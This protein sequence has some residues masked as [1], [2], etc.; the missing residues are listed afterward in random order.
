MIGHCANRSDVWNGDV[1]SVRVGGVQ[2]QLRH[3]I[4]AGTMSSGQAVIEEEEELRRTF[5][6]QI[7][8]H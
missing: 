6:W 3:T 7:N 1:I 2:L 5:I 4:S 8:V